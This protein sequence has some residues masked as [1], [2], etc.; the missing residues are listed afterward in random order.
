MECVLYELCAV[1]TVLVE[2]VC[3]VHNICCLSTT[4]CTDIVCAFA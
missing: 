2:S 3:C 4:K 1:W